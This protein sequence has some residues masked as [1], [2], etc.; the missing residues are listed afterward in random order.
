MK[1]LWETFAA[2]SDISK[3]FNREGY[4]NLSNVLW[5]ITKS[6][7]GIVLINLHL[8]NLFPSFLIKISLIT[9]PSE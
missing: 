4:G 2:R 6:L 5:Y 1:S 9:A 8:R 3:Y 7:I